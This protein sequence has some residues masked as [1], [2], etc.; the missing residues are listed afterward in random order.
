MTET[1]LAA[2]QYLNEAIALARQNQNPDGTYSSSYLHRTG[3]T[4]DLGESIGTTGHGVEF[5]SMAAADETLRQPWVERSVR[6][7]CDMLELCEGIDLECGVL[8]HALHGLAL[9]EKRLVRHPS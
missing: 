3:W 7:L 8:Y 2:R 9:Y 6:R 4:R 1:W 5:L